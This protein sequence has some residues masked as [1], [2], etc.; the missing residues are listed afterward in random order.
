MTHTRNI[1]EMLNIPTGSRWLTFFKSLYHIKY[2]ELF[3]ML[4]CEIF[5]H[6]KVM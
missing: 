5:R 1:K 6:I 4:E 2:F 3:E